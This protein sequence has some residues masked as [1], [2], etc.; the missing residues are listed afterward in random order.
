MIGEASPF[1]SFDA[2]RETSVSPMIHDLLVVCIPGLVETVIKHA[3]RLV[4]RR[5]VLIP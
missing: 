5:H 4:V 2:R 3:Q 1:G